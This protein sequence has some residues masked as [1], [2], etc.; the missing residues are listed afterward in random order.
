MNEPR[1]IQDHLP[2]SH[3]AYHI[4]LVLAG[5]D[6]SPAELSVEI[7][8]RTRGAIRCTQAEVSGVIRKLTQRG[9]VEDSPLQMDPENYDDYQRTSA[10]TMLGMQV[11]AAE[12]IRIAG[13]LSLALENRLVTRDRLRAALPR[14]ALG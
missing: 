7:G 10:L 3:L 13:A 12:T 2:L 5:G 6:Q 9:Y 1:D 11:A 4:L 14:A 8:E